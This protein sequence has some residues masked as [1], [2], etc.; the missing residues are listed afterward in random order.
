MLEYTEKLPTK[1]FRAQ[2]DGF[3]SENIHDRDAETRN[4]LA[5]VL[6]KM[7]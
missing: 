5:F 3:K 1:I 2:M 7:I 4:V 6:N